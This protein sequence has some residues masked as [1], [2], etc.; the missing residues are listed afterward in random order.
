[1]GVYYHREDLALLKRSVSSI[2]DQSFSD[3][4]LLICDDGSTQEATLWLRQAA[5]ADAR[6]RLI[7]R[8]DGLTSLPAKLNACLQQARGAFV[9]RM[10]DDDFS[11]PDRFEKQ[12]RFLSAHTSVAFLGSNVELY[13]AGKPIGTRQLPEKPTVQD[14]FFTQPY[15][16][17]ALMFRREALQA[18]HGYSEDPHCILCED[19][20]LLLRLYAA[21]Y[22]GMNLQESLLDY[23]LPLRARGSR[24]MRHRWNEAVTRYRRFRDL[25]ALPQAFPYVIKPLAVGMLPEPVLKKVKGL[26]P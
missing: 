21:G 20:D 8:K 16:H 1:M 15:V 3:L 9:A 14:F 19:Y 5:R 26:R 7:H 4:E 6:I 18:V 22:H 23:T 17:P 10:D 24:K 25:G 13:Q 12:L 11:H 2:L